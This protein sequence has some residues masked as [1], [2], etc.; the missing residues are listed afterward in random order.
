MKRLS[1]FAAMGFSH[2]IRFFVEVLST[3][4]RQMGCTGGTIDVSIVFAIVTIVEAEAVVPPE[5]TDKP[6]VCVG[7][8]I[9]DSARN[10]EYSLHD[11]LF[12]AV[13]VLTK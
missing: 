12:P 5:P 3:V 7:I 9:G 8:V 1:I 11:E 2:T 4:I 13:S 10:K 6:G